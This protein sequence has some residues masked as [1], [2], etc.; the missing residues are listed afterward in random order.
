MLPISS[1]TSVAQMRF[2]GM[3]LKLK[4][5]WVRFHIINHSAFFAPKIQPTMTTAVDAFAL[6]ALTFCDR[7]GVQSFS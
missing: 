2:S 7:G 6:V 1:T 3:K 4:G 5:R